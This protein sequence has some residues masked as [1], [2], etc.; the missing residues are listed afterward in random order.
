MTHVYEW[1]SFPATFSIHCPGCGA[2]AIFTEE[3]GKFRHPP[4]TPIAGRS[5]A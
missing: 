4:D 1:Y 5:S 2:E 3:K